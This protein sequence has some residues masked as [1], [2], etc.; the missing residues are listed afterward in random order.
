[1]IVH[2]ITM[3]KRNEQMQEQKME[4]CGYGYLDMHIE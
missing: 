4:V 2:G 3:M 1:M